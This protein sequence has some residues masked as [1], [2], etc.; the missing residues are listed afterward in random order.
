MAAL[1]A[2]V[3]GGLNIFLFKWLFREFRTSKKYSGTSSAILAI[4]WTFQVP[5]WHTSVQGQD[6]RARGSW[7]DEDVARLRG[8]GCHAPHKEQAIM[9][10]SLYNL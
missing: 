3:A 8:G 1:A 5:Y 4:F 6:K 10:G 2:A 7:R 9:Q